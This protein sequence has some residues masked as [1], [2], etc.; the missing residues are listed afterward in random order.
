[1]IRHLALVRASAIDGTKSS[2]TIKIHLIEQLP[3]LIK[4]AQSSDVRKR[5]LRKR[6]DHFAEMASIRIVAAGESHAP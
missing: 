3:H 1:M 6:I 5:S 4:V 2:A